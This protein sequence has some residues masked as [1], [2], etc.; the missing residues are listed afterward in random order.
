[1]RNDKIYFSFPLLCLFIDL[2]I[3][4][5]KLAEVNENRKM[6]TFFIFVFTF[7]V[8]YDILDHVYLK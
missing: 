4:Y 1:M 7:N 2:I 5:N 3:N 8:K 6:V